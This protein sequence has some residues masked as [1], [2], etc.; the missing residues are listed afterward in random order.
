MMPPSARKILQGNVHAANLLLDQLDALADPLQRAAAMV[1][2]AL[3]DGRQLLCCGNGGSAADCG[4]LAT[5]IT[6]R[7]L[8]ERPGFAAID[9]TA[10][11]SLV[12]ALV[13]DYPPQQVFARQVQAL[14]RPKDV[15]MALSTSGRSVNIQ[16]ALE[17]ARANRMSTIALLGCDGGVC[18]GMADV[19]L[20]VPS[21]TTARIQEVHLLL[22]HT[23]W[24]LIDPVLAAG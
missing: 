23:I 11:H 12:T 1:L 3:T 10:N 19:E 21:R 18:K 17:A 8:L 5:E 20:I 2:A 16:R 22:C 7:Y 24:D 4:H 15:L 13:N 9:L 6:G 14:G